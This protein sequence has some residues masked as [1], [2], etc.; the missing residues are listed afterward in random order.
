[1]ENYSFV[2][3]SPTNSENTTGDLEAATV[4][5]HDL[6]KLSRC[7]M[8]KK[9]INQYVQAG[10]KPAVLGNMYRFLTEDESAHESRHQAAFLLNSYSTDLIYDMKRNNGRSDYSRNS[11]ML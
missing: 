1:M 6:P 2:R 10:T 11:G 8:R 9:V 7:A 5:K 3:K 4:I